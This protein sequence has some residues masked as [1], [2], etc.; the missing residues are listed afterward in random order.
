MKI[1]I[2]KEKGII[3]FNNKEVKLQ[4]IYYRIL[5]HYEYNC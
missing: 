1:K 4:M 2:N 3:S 5:Y